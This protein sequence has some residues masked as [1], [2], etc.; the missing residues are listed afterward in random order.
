[1]LNSSKLGVWAA[2]VPPSS[3][4]LQFRRWVRKVESL[5]SQ[6]MTSGKNE[7]QDHLIFI[8][9][10]ALHKR[11]FQKENGD[12]GETRPTEKEEGILSHEKGRRKSFWRRHRSARNT[13][14]QNSK[15]TKKRSKRNELEELKLDMRK[16]SNDMEEMCGILNLYMYED[17]NYRM[18]TEF[19]IIKS[20]HEKTMLDMNKM[21]QSIIGSM[22]YSMELIED[23]YSYSIK[24]DHLLREC[25]QLN[26]NVRIL[27]NENRRLLVEQAGHKCP[28]GKKRGSL[29]R[30]ARTSV[31]QVPRNSSPAES[32]TWHR[33]GNDLPQREVLEEEH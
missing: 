3:P 33:P 12:E 4:T 17:L 32:R 1:M 6:P 24:E 8:S 10:K 31:S 14:T 13:S 27:L 9:E 2:G 26:E 28:V 30:P 16:I 20:Q 22:Q 18:N 23:N 5:I 11:L 15:M 29:R 21:I 19:N 25:T 7:L